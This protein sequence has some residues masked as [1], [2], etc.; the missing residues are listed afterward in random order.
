MS[1]IADGTERHQRAFPL[2][3]RAL[4]RVLRASSLL[5]D[6]QRKSPTSRRCERLSKWIELHYAKY[7]RYKSNN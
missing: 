1:D 3:A 7:D 6:E 5:G 2:E 4:S